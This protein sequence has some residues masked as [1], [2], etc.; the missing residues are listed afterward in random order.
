MLLGDGSI[1]KTESHHN[2]CL[3]ITHSINQ[4]DYL[5]YKMNLLSELGVTIGNPYY[6]KDKM[7]CRIRTERSEIFTVLRKR[8]YHANGKK[9]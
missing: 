7:E 6:R 1:C 2:N 9:Y 4:K 8:C 5:F 3:E